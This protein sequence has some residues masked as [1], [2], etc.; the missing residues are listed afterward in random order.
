MKVRTIFFGTPQFAVPIL[1]MLIKHPNLEVVLIVA[2][3]DKPVGRKKV[4]TPPP[5]KELGMRN[6]IE[7]F[8]PT[9]LRTEES[10]NVIQQHKPELIVVAAYGKIV[11]ENILNL[12]K[13]KCLN[14][15]PSQ[16]PKYRGA[17]PIQFAL[18][19]GEEKT[20]TTIMLMEPTLDTGPI[21]S[22]E[23]VTIDYEETYPQLAGKLANVSAQLLSKTLP[24]WLEGTITSE[25]QDDS[26]ATFTK[27]L[28]KEDGKIDWQKTATQI[29][30]QIRAFTPWPGTHTTLDGK[31]LKILQA[32][33][34]QTTEIRGTAG[35]IYYKDGKQLLISCGESTVLEVFELQPEGKKAMSAADFIRGYPNLAYAVLV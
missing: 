33:P 9:T 19:N 7:V 17:S 15:H 27:I 10:L 30:N 24:Q 12:P 2:Q 22:Q 8:Q 34:F 28:E 31:F 29:H 6:K 16:L 20:A 25:K 32:K 13:Y 4:L 18:L 14:V 11:P 26:Q 5:T 3:P 35:I 1:D 23:E 21:L